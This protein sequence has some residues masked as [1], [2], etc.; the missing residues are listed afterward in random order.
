MPSAR[1]RTKGFSAM[2]LR[3]MFSLLPFLVLSDGE[4]ASDDGDDSDATGDRDGAGDDTS[5]RN[6]SDALGDKGKAAIAAERKARRDAE[7]ARKAAEDRA[8]KLEADAKKRAD[9]EAAKQGQWQELA[10][11]REA[12]L[13]ES[14]TTLESV[15]AQLDEAMTILKAETDATWKA[16]PEEVRELY[17]GDDADVLAKRKHL[18]RSKKLIER[19]AKTD[20]RKPRNGPNPPAGDGRFDE[21]AAIENA[22]ATGKY[23]I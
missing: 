5:D 22:R 16:I 18:T 11:K 2:L 10:E 7:A 9:D 3:L 12:D 20:E 23:A 19:L 1:C 8:D 17:D 15:Q 13:T 14:Q 4:D 21:A 6:D